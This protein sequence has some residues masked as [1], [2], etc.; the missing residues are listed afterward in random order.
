MPA[1][2]RPGLIVVDSLDEAFTYDPSV[3]LVYAFGGIGQSAELGARCSDL[4]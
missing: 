3:N 4:T 2:A 1:P